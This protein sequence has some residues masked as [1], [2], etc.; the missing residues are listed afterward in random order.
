[1]PFTITWVL[2]LEVAGIETVTRQQISA[3]L[4]ASGRMSMIMAKGG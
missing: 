3:Y 2:F 1:M 4:L